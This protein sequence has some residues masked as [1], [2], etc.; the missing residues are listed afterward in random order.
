MRV[1]IQCAATKDRNA[2][3][4]HT[5]DGRKVAFVADPALAPPEQGVLYAHPDDPSDQPG[6]TWRDRVAAE[7][8]PGATYPW[9]LMPA[10]ELY[11]PRIYRA[12]T[13]RFG[14]EQVFILSAGWG[15]VRSD[16]RLPAYDI[17]FA[18]SAAP[19]HRR[20]GIAGYRDGVAGVLWEP[21]EP[22]L[23]FLGGRAYLPLFEHLTATYG[24][25]RL[26]FYPQLGPDPVVPNLPGCATQAFVTT[27]RTNW[28]YA[29]A[30]ALIEGRIMPDFSG[31]VPF[32]RDRFTSGLE[33]IVWVSDGPGTQE[34]P[35]PNVP[36]AGHGQSGS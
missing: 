20:R 5:V 7:N 4:F 29:C 27:Q 9:G 36:A 10:G 31:A 35:L 22:D 26:V 25:R 23:V 24:G 30:A 18:A 12:L 3:T 11:S 14:V 21:P 1:V 17:A 16:W 34:E 33:D 2:G 28:H 8:A 19:F 32:R 13:A 6:L 15:L